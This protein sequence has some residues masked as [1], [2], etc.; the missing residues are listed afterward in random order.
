VWDAGYRAGGM[1][2]EA[3]HII[4]YRYRHK[5][6]NPGSNCPGK[7]SDDWFFHTVGEYPYGKLSG[8]KHSM[9]QMEVEFNCDLSQFAYPTIPVMI[10]IAAE[11][12]A[13]EL[14]DNQI[15]NP[16]GWRCGLPR[17]LPVPPKRQP[18]PNGQTCCDPT[19]HPA[20]CTECVPPGASCQ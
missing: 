18:C 19:P 7:C 8:H 12:N 5:S 13:N 15:R 9:V 4:Y 2:H 3:T 1:L 6:N 17:P 11:G 16:P 20:G 14:M 10:K